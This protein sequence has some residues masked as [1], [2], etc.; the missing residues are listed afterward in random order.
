LS[1]ITSESMKDALAYTILQHINEEMSLKGVTNDIRLVVVL[2]EAWRLCRNPDG[3]PVK[4][5]KAG[6]KFGYSLIVATQDA[7]ADLAESILANSGTVIIHH[8]EHSKYLRFYKQSFG[9]TDQEI[10]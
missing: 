6:R 1:H 3:L 9:L 5:V 8:T 10:E 7:T 2:D 4:I